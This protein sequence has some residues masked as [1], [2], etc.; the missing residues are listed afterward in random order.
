[1]ITEQAFMTIYD[2]FL[3]SGLSVRSYC[4]NQGMNEAKFFYWQR[5]LKNKLPGQK[6]FVPLVFENDRFDPRPTKSMSRHAFPEAG[7]TKGSFFEITYPNG[8][9]LKLSE[10]ADLEM[11]RS[12]LLLAR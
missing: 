4:T 6:G 8:V 5:K 9:M 2:D 11:I 7:T 1:M 12:L 10:D 3:E